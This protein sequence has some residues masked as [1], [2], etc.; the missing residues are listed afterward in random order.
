MAS[1]MS[2]LTNLDDLNTNEKRPTSTTSKYSTTMKIEALKEHLGA[3]D[4]DDILQC[5]QEIEIFYTDWKDYEKE[6]AVMSGIV[7]PDFI[8][9]KLK[10]FARKHDLIF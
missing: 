9:Y 1:R 5:L 7:G 8:K 10:E 6:D 2:I 3:P 4:Y